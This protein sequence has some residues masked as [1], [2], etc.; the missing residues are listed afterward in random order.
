VWI[1]THNS[2][3]VDSLTFVGIVR[4]YVW[5]V[6]ELLLSSLSYDVLNGCVSGQGD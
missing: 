5:N 2:T 6:D 1:L 4:M 3:F